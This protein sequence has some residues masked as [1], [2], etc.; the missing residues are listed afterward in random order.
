MVKK[1][2]PSCE[3]TFVYFEATKDIIT[4]SGIE[5]NK[6]AFDSRDNEDFWDLYSNG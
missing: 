1:Y 2:L 5:Q 3:I 4:T 6:N